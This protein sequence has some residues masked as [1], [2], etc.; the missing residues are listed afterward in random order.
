M[1]AKYVLYIVTMAMACAA[2]Q[3]ARNASPAVVQ[4][5]PGEAEELLIT[6]VVPQYPSDG[7]FNQIQNNEVLEIRIDELGNV[8]DAHVQSGHPL[9]AQPSL[10]A[11]RQW[12]FRPYLVNDA[13]VTVDTTV[14]IAFRFS[15]LEHAPPIP[16]GVTPCVVAMATPVEGT[17]EFK[18]FQVDRKR[19]E[20]MLIT[21]VDPPYPQFAKIAH[22]QGDVVIYARIDKLGHVAKLNPMGGHPIL[23]QAA[24]DAVKQWTYKPYEVSGEA[25]AV[26][27]IVRVQFRMDI[28]APPK[29]KT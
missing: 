8:A 16:K 4:L 27:G 26:E 22:I 20:E 9:F 2:Q 24:M 18:G 29:A 1:K 3:P 11:V 28:T 7:R 12:K 17:D 15:G 14:L 25:V 10:E 19:L 5:S 6:S 23:V 21:R 13:P